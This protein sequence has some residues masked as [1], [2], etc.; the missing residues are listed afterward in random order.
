MGHCPVRYHA[1]LHGGTWG[2]YLSNE[3]NNYAPLQETILFEIDANEQIHK[4]GSSWK[5]DRDY[6]LG[7]ETARSTPMREDCKAFILQALSEAG[8]AMPTDD[9]DSKVKAAGYS[10]TGIKRAKTDLKKEGAIKYFHTGS[11]QDRVWH[12]QLSDPD[13]FIEVSEEGPTP[14]EKTAFP[15]DISK[16]V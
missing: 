10:F 16:V 4:A 12:T 8:G 1:G 13:G 2:R 9:L 11:P 15:S 5:R 3:K 7:A 14:F 6:I